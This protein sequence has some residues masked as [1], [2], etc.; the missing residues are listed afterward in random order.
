MR[1]WKV[2]RRYKIIQCCSP[3]QS[4]GYAANYAF[5]RREKVSID[6]LYNNWVKGQ[7]VIIE[8]EYVYNIENIKLNA[9]HMWVI[10]GL[11]RKSRNRYTFSATTDWTGRRFW[12]IE[13][14]RQNFAQSH[15]NWG[16]GGSSDL[17]GIICL[18][19]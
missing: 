19:P 10:D 12:E 15:N 11:Y 2:I 1:R 6:N 17:G 8:C 3:L 5:D 13:K 9:G 14:W 4:L 16:W 18:L 7:P